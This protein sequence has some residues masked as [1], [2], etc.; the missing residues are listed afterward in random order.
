MPDSTFNTA[1]A[2]LQT[3]EL[4]IGY[5]RT[6]ISAGSG[7]GGRK[8]T[9]KGLKP[10]NSHAQQTRQY[11]AAA[12][13]P[14]A[15]STPLNL[16]LPKGQLTCLM[17]PNGA[18]KSTLL[19]TLAGLHPPLQG[20]VWLNGQNLK[21]LDRQTRART[22]SIVLS[23]PPPLQGLT[24]AQLV[25]TGL[26]P[27]SNWLGAPPANSRAGINEAMHQTEVYHLRHRLLNTL[28]DGQQQRAMIA[29]ALAQGGQ[30]MLLDE[31]TAHLDL[32]HKLKVVT[33]LQNIAQ[34]QQKAILLATHDLETTLEAASHLWLMLAS[35][36]EPNATPKPNHHNLVRLVQGMPEDL[37]LQGHLPQA[38]A[39]KPLLFNQVSG[40]FEIMRPDTGTVYVQAPAPAQQPAYTWT[41]HALRR[42][43]FK[44]PAATSTQQWPHLQIQKGQWLLTTG[45]QMAAQPFNTLAALM[46]FLTKPAAH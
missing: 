9:S 37:L 27:Q 42:H 34:Q 14:Q 44:A 8:G 28:S 13:G 5:A 26:L 10:A 3:K 21:N 20:S 45:P 36:P 4:V 31:P 29:R 15:L 12:H 32:A 46:A 16:A 18:G 1:P 43:G 39:H 40:R 41:L 17:G 2:L 23:K 6:G 22:L 35:T 30:V 7:R 33:L 25:A 19:S 11:N 38:F 24:V